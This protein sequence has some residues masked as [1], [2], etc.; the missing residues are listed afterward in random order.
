MILTLADSGTKEFG[1]HGPQKLLK[2]F[3][4]FKNFLKR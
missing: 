2:C 3:V 1:I 4:G